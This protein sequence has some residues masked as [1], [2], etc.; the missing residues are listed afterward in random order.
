[1]YFR[2]QLDLSFGSSCVLSTALVL[3]G[4]WRS[5]QL[6]G[7]T[8]RMCSSIR[9]PIQTMSAS[10]PFSPPHRATNHTFLSSEFLVHYLWLLSAPALFATRWSSSAMSSKP[11]NAASLLR[12]MMNT[13]SPGQSSW[14]WSQGWFTLFLTHLMQTYITQKTSTSLST[15]GVQG[16]TGLVDTHRWALAIYVIK[17]K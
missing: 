16:T 8:E 2:L 7:P 10:L 15:A 1:M 14:I 5:L 13:T 9:W 11:S 12:L 17:C 6:K 3:R 4:L